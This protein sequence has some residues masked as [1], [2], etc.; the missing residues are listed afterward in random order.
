MKKWKDEA[1][2]FLAVSL[3]AISAL[4]VAWLMK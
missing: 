1:R 3:M 2:F 4:F